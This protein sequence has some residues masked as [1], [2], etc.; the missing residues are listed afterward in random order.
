MSKDFASLGVTP[1]ILKALTARGYETPTPIQAGSI[2][3]LLDAPDELIVIAARETELH[4]HA[5]PGA[6]RPVVADDLGGG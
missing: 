5:P 6:A 2:P 3:H 4:P 1:T